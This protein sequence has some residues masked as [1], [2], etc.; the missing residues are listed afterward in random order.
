MAE[1]NLALCLEGGTEQ[2]E[3]TGGYSASLT[4]ETLTPISDSWIFI[5]KEK[6]E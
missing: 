1:R 5:D 4:I 3:K 6:I 2:V